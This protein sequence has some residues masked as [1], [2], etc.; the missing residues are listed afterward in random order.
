MLDLE[1]PLSGPYA[2]D[3][4]DENRSPTDSNRCIKAAVSMVN[5]YYGGHLSQDR[6]AY[7]VYHEYLHFPSPED[8]F[9]S[10][11]G[12]IDVNL[13]KVLSWALN[14]APVIRLDG[15]PDFSEIKNFI[16]NNLPTI[17]D[18]G[19]SHLITVIE[20][21]DTDGQMVYLIDPL[22]GTKTKVPYDSLDFFCCWVPAGSNITARS[23]EPTIWM[24]SDHDGVVDFDEIN[25]FHTDPYDNDTYGLGI[26]DKKVI[27]YTY[28]DHLTFPT[29]AFTFAPQMPLTNEKITFNA[30]ET[31]G[32]ITAYTWKFGDS[33]T[34]TVTEP[35]INHAYNQQGTYNVTLTVNDTNGLWNTTTSSLTVGTQDRNLFDTAFYR[36]SLDRNGYA[37]TEGPETSDILWTSD[38]NDSVTTSPAAANGK[39]FD[40][41][42]SGKFYALDLT[43]GDIVWTFDAGSPISSSPAFQGGVVFF[44]TE[45]PGKIYAVDAD[46]GI[47]KWLYDVPS[48]AAV[49]S[50][51]AVVEGKVIVGSSDGN[52]LCLDQEEGHVLWRTHVGSGYLSSAA[53]QNDTAFVASTFGVYAVDLSTGTLIWEYAT[54]WPVISC[55]AVADGLVFVGSENNDRVYALDERTGQ[56]LWIFPTG[57]WLTPPAVDSSKQLVIVGSKDY[58]LYCLSEQTGSVEW[59]YVN[60]RNYLSDPTISANGLVY[61]GTYDGSLHCVNEDTGEEVW[62]YNLT[63][64]IASSATVISGHVLVASQDG[65]IYCF[66]PPFALHN[67]AITSLTES[68][69]E[70]GQGY[71]LN[72]NATVHNTGDAVETFN[73]TAYA[74]GTAIE[75]KEM[76]LTNG[77]S[78]SVTFVW[79][80]TSF[81]YGNYTISAYAT[82]VPDETNTTDNNIFG[83]WVTVTIPGDLNCDF[84]VGLADL[85]I[86]AKAYSSTHGDSTWSPNADIDNNG[87]V[88][89]SDLVILAQHYGQHYP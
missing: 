77:S 39:V 84:T 79:D 83:G 15:K 32:N 70:V 49:Y 5:S 51:P 73:V 12:V 88:G 45:N 20:G 86:L 31:E 63:A 30:S 71:S 78:T 19:P 36:Q 7:Y 35:A 56:P 44:G 11:L 69:P 24:D 46:T 14:G 82:P 64:P 48:G 17:R 16:D 25:R 3:I 42:S 1:R 38:L 89:L 18:N 65:E 87:T 27:E 60:G 57:G 21:Y 74:N 75:T 41:T 85:V 26:D 8:D 23:D 40:G 50:S 22:N 59:K 10:G 52:L 34:T 62:T 66:G 81:A 2:W 53:I 72:I 6:I 58:T 43:T 28:M 67:I 9:G 37:A 68:S 54:S 29:T 33:N 13:F 47:I 4:P 55:P 61:V 76:T 80:T